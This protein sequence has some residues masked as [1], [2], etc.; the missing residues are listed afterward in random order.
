MLRTSPESY[1]S[2]RLMWITPNRS[3]YTGLLGVPS[4]R[5]IGSVIVYVAV[6]GNIR[7][8]IGDGAWESA[9]MAV[10]PPY[11]PHWVLAEARQINTINIEAEAV[12]LAALPEVLRGQGAVDA[13]WFVEHV[14]ACQRMLCGS[15]V[16]LA[17]I[18]FDELFFST[19][20]APR[21]MDRRI[22]AVVQAIQRD[23]SA[24][25]SA[26]TC[27]RMA[28]LS[29]SRFLHLF[30]QEAGMPFRIF[31]TWKRARGMLHYVNQKSNL[32]RVALDTGYPDSTHF[33][34]SIRQ[35][36]GLKP[37]DIFAGSRRL[38]VYAQHAA[39]C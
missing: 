8:R 13:P 21:R 10:V 39:P 9:Q 5:S 18:D 30:K 27:A 19:A 15:D 6:E 35:I 33:S 14:R 20:L 23:P 24:P 37:K 4:Q 34:H 12:D 32:T 36:Y 26:E 17:A 31:R 29:Y 11:T 38:T 22:E 1:V 7:V 3:F 25:L 2:N 16:D 28:G